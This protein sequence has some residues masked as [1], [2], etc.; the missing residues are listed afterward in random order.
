MENKKER[1][2]LLKK[3]DETGK[4]EL[5]EG[6]LWG[7]V[8]DYPNDKEIL[9]LLD[10]TDRKI[11][12]ANAETDKKWRQLSKNFAE[13]DNTIQFSEKTLAQMR[14]KGGVLNDKEILELLDLTNRKIEEANAETDKKWSQLS[15]NFVEIDNTI[16]FSEKTLAQMG[17]KVGVLQDSIGLF[18][19]NIED[20]QR[21]ERQQW[22]EQISAR[23]TTADTDYL[24]RLLKEKR[25]VTN[26]LTAV[27]I[28]HQL[29]L[30]N[31]ALEARDFTGA[32]EKS[33][34]VLRSE[35]IN[36]TA[37]SIWSFA[38]VSMAPETVENQKQILP[39]VEYIILQVPNNVMALQTAAMIYQASGNFSLAEERF[40]KAYEAR[41]DS[42]VIQKNYLNTLIQLGKQTAGLP[43][44]QKLWA[45]TSKSDENG[46]LVW[47][48]M[49]AEPIDQRIGFLQTWKK[50]I[51]SSPLPDT[52][53]GELAYGEGNK[54]EAIDFFEF[55][56]KKRPT[57]SIYKR[58]ADISLEVG[59]TVSAIT[60][61]HSII[62]ILN[63]AA[64]SDRADY[65]NYGRLLIQTEYN[66]KKYSDVLID[67]ETYLKNSP[68]ENDLRFMVAKSYELT[69]HNVQALQEYENIYASGNI[70][71]VA[72]PILELY[73]TMKDYD[74]VK[75]KGT[76]ILSKI[77]D[78]DLQSN[79]KNIMNKAED[80]KK[81][82]K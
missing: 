48:C 70:E 11:E 21:I 26:Q 74:A 1:L 10:L 80:L 3:F 22:V 31:S 59:D 28:D 57:K 27:E 43:I 42:V 25:I 16:Q 15:K 60:Y 62:N 52:Y 39:V 69:G 6:L 12:E 2:S 54:K 53:L 71:L 36:T 61:M 7:L 33:A 23:E 76:A 47:Q 35:P 50:T 30:A 38:T 51:P 20:F 82:N 78:K 37:A 18:Q 56:V 14:T 34:N 81:A 55:V 9:E 46:L 8:R 24:F 72:C 77:T 19:S 67:S 40:R 65:I 45:E 32:K 64:E 75:K 29:V 63:I 44:A 66:E 68:T 41:P 4:T 79:I 73:S 13:I 58:L 49:N 5:A 17:T